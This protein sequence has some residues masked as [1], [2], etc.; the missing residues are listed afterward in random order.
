MIQQI[1]DYKTFGL[2]YDL[3]TQEWAIITNA[4]LNPSKYLVLT[5]QETQVAQV[6]IIVGSLNL[7]MMEAHILVIL[8]L[9]VTFL[10]VN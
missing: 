3:D 6:L 2:R 5:M 4:N 9:L 1:G 10:K 7:Q 8:D